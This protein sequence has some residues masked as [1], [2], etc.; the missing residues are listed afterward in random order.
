[1]SSKMNILIV[2]KQP[3]T[4]VLPEMFGRIIDGILEDDMPAEIKVTLVRTTDE[5]SASLADT[6]V[7]VIDASDQKACEFAIDAQSEHG[8]PCIVLCS[9]SDR[10]SFIECEDLH[11]VTMST[12]DGSPPLK[13]LAEALQSL[14]RRHVTRL[15][16]R[17]SHYGNTGREESAEH[18]M[19]GFNGFSFNS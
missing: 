5:A 15:K 9:P 18:D 11:I 14:W 1:M 12:M 10:P 19:H 16:G 3:A 8:I 6:H 4:A 17:I 13:E 7:L 2:Q